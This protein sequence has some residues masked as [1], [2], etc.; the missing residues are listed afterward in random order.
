MKMKDPHEIIN[1]LSP[2]DA[3][4]ILRALA[5]SDEQLADRIGEMGMA[6]LKG[7]DPE[8]VAATLYKE[9]DAL[10][11]E[12]VWERA[13]STQYGYEVERGEAAYEMVEETLAPFLAELRRYQKIGMAT[14][15][16]RLCI[17]LLLGLYRFEH[18]S[19]SEFKDLAPDASRSFSWTVVDM[20]EDGGPSRA[21]VKVVRAFIEE[22]LGGWG[23]AFS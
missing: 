20:W 7:V 14:E 8:R 22:E 5:D 19:T 23:W 21:D 13:G 9:L 2:S 18:E 16:K 17:G 3:L 1:Q 15:A 10:E 12:E 6:R 11:A 4:T